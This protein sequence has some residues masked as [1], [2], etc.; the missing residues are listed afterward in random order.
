VRVPVLTGAAVI[1]LYHRIASTTADPWALNVSRRHFDEHMAIVAAQGRQTRLRDVAAALEDASDVRDAIAVTF[2]DG[3]AN[4][5]HEALPILEKHG[6]PATIFVPSLAVDAERELWWD[7]LERLLLEPGTLPASLRLET[8]EGPFEYALA[9]DNDHRSD[10][11][12]NTESWR[13]WSDE[14]PTKRH[15]LYRALWNR[16][17]LMSQSERTGA[18]DA[19]RTW[20][21]VADASPRPTHRTLTTSELATLC[22]S[23]LVDLG[24]HTQTHPSLA[25]LPVA[26]QQ[27]EIGVAKRDLESLTGR[28]IT[29]FAYPFGKREDYTPQTVEIVRETGHT[30]ACVNY[31]AVTRP[32]NSRFELPRL[33]VEDWSGDELERRLASVCR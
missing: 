13:A 22:S 33:F 26:C 17:R 29:A 31:G 8:A 4:N 10:F 16:C 30:C 11:T 7:E 20:A 15:D 27:D 19:L 28:S 14:T 3:Y 21:G 2:D 12:S 18:L 6:V 9:A 1:L 23:P 25:R 24:S 5:L 32:A